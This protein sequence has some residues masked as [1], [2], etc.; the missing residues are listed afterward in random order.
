MHAIDTCKLVTKLDGYVFISVDWSFCPHFTASSYTVILFP[1]SA[2]DVMLISYH[3]IISVFYFT[4]LVL[5]T[6]CRLSML[7]GDNS[8]MLFPKWIP[9][10]SH[11]R[12]VPVR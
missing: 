4:M 12:Q 9:K 2:H 5:H 3:T 10:I 8:D 6:V 11:F 7:T 1:T